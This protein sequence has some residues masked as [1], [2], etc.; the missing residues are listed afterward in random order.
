MSLGREWEPGSPLN[1]L[2]LNTATLPPLGA[3]VSVHG[4]I[5]QQL[6]RSR[7]RAYAACH[8]DRSHPSPTFQLLGGIS[9]LEICPVDLGREVRGQSWW[10]KIEKVLSATRAVMGFARLTSLVW[11]KNIAV[12]HSTD[13]PRD[14]LICVLLSRITPARSMVHL[15]VAYGD[16]MNRMRRWSLR[17]ADVVITVSDFVKQTLVDSGH[18]LARIHSVRNGIDVKSLTRSDRPRAVRQELGIPEAAPVIL[19]VC[20]LF[21][22]KGP[23]DLVAA[24]PKLV[25][26]WPDLR[27]VIVGVEMEGGYKAKLERLARDNGASAVEAH[28]KW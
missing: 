28:L 2:F 12:V 5:L 24:L 20:R 26:D 8:V 25:C 10:A 19:T 6:D 18:D 14:A 15:H 4:T 9:D 3:D 16:W 13:R 11:R 21:P 23:G 17:H 7:F 1:V 27:L 22:A